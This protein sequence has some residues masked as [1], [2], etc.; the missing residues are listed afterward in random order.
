LN[1]QDLADV[2]FPTFLKYLY[3]F[4]FRPWV[5]VYAGTSDLHKLSYSALRDVDL[6]SNNRKVNTYKNQKSC[7]ALTL[8]S[9]NLSCSLSCDCKSYVSASLQAFNIFDAR[10]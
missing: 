8:P 6:A 7:N 5:K 1:K 9:S 2:R 3:M 4:D 10:H